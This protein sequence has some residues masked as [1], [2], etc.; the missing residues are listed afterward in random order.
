MAIIALALVN[1]AV[2]LTAER[3]LR[4]LYWLCRPLRQWR[5]M[6]QKHNEREPKKCERAA[7]LTELRRIGIREGA[8][9]M[10][11]AGV[12]GLAIGP[13][14]YDNNPVSQAQML[15]EDLLGLLGPE[16]TLVMP[17]HARYQTDELI[18]RRATCGV[19]TYDPRRTPCG[20][21]LVSE[22][23]WRRKGVQRS[24]FPYNMLAACGPLAEELLRENVN[25][26]RPSP[27][28]V[29]SGYYRICQQNGLVA[30][31]GVRL[32]EC[33]TIAHVVEETRADWPIADFFEERRYRVV[34]NGESKEWTVR[35]RRT[36]YAKY[37]YCRKKVGR[38]LVDEGVIHEGQV[39]TVPVDWARAKE[40][41]DF[42]YRK[43]EPWPYPYYGRWFMP[44]PWTRPA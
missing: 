26:R 1:D 20:V 37:C 36:E 9:V 16:G 13:T 7:L 38:D 25:E 43:T 21:G 42:F 8:L 34:D 3:S 35:Q 6:R 28:G 12:N 14:D 44:K 2:F 10:V 5:G 27:H 15:L 31:I 17:T 18:E 29:D 30:A 24:L 33:I 19:T 32:R 22:L 23:F 40:V 4:Q 11:H 39:G 41:Y